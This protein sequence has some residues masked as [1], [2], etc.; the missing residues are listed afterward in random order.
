MKKTQCLSLV[1]STLLVSSNSFADPRVEGR[2]KFGTE[3]RSTATVTQDKI[4]LGDGELSTL[5]RDSANTFS[6]FAKNKIPKEEL[7]KAR[8]IAIFPKI[9]SA[10]VV[11][12]GG[13][14]GDGLAVCRNDDGKYSRVG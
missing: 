9:A 2:A 7:A 13:Y 1:F 8:C 5:F 14:A 10:G 11:A 3:G 12:V 6:E 4:Q